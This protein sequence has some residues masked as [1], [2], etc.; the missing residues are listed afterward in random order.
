MIMTIP[1]KKGKASK[2]SS[3]YV[4]SHGLTMVKIILHKFQLCQQKTFLA[5]K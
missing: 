3:N 4:T 5:R 1:N 2:V